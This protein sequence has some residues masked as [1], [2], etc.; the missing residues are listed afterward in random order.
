MIVKLVKIQEKYGSSSTD[1]MDYKVTMDSREEH[2]L[3]RVTDI[4]RKVTKIR[5]NKIFPPRPSNILRS[6]EVSEHSVRFQLAYTPSWQS[7]HV[8]ASLVFVI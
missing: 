4:V 1:S 5:V 6:S 2:F 7:I 3:P 8:G